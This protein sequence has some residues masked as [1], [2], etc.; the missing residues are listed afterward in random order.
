M[1]FFYGFIYQNSDGPGSVVPKIEN[2]RFSVVKWK[3]IAH[4]L[5]NCPMH[6]ILVSR[7]FPGSHFIL[8]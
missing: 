4:A 8:D 2:S 7:A 5:L 6:D 3:K 1:L